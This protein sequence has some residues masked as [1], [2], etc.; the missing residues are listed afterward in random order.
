MRTS[1]Y[2]KIFV[3]QEQYH[4]EWDR[5]SQIKA[6][7]FQFSGDPISENDRGNAA[8]A[9]IIKREL[10]HEQEKNQQG[11]RKESKSGY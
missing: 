9:F 8:L 5:I 3:S 10:E 1:Q 7:D 2:Q 4:E 11:V 6:I